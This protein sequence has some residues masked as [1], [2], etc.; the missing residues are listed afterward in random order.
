MNILISSVMLRLRD[1]Q[2]DRIREYSPE[3][4]ILDSRLGR[5]GTC[6]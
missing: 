4:H 3:E 6:A 5:K 1:N 2:R